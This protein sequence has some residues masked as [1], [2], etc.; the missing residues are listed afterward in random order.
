MKIIKKNLIKSETEISNYRLVA[1]EVFFLETLYTF[2]SSRNFDTKNT[3]GRCIKISRD[4]FSCQY[5][6]GFHFS[7][8]KNGLCFSRYIG[9]FIRLFDKVFDLKTLTWFNIISSL[10]LIRI[11]F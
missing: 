8:G 1:F 5:L 3:K 9:C 4:P 2:C 6:F 7:C 11:N 10:K